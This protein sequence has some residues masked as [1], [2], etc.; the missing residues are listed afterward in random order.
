MFKTS[1]CRAYKF[2]SAHFLPKVPKEH[3]C[4]NMHGHNYRVEIVVKGDVDARGFILDFYELDAVI[5]PLI[6]LVDHK[7]LNEVPGL[8]NPTAENIAAWFLSRV[9]LCQSV[10]V[11][12]N[13]ESWAQVSR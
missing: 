8:E 9:S 10:R 12:E 13:D 7:V 6:K 2:E 5:L 11:Y 4:H 3:R 1:V